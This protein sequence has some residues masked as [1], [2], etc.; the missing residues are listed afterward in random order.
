[1]GPPKIS[2]RFLYGSTLFDEK[3]GI[4][5]PNRQTAAAGNFDGLSKTIMIGE[6]QRL[7][8]KTE[9]TKVEQA[10]RTSNDGWATAGVASLFDNMDKL[11]LKIMRGMMKMQAPRWNK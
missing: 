3:T 9:G 10:S 11:I 6:M 2:H 8:P 1:V 5:V 7:Y 4:F